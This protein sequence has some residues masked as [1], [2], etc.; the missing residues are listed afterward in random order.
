MRRS[1]LFAVF[2]LTTTSVVAD[3]CRYGF[4][5]GD[6]FSYGPIT[7]AVFADFNE[8]GR[9]DFITNEAA[10]NVLYLN[11]GDGH[12]ER[13]QL[14]LQPGGLAHYDL[15]AAADANGDGHMDLVLDG[16]IAV[17]L[18][19]GKGN[20]GPLIGSG[21]P[22]PRSARL[23]DLN[24][25]GLKDVVYQTSFS[26]SALIV[27]F[28]LGDG[29]FGPPTEIA[30]PLRSDSTY[31]IGDFDGDGAPDLF[32][33]NQVWWNDGKGHFTPS[34][35][36]T[37]D[38]SDVSI[39]DP[40]D[41]DHDGADD[42]LFANATGLLKL[43]RLRGRIVNVT[44]VTSDDP[45][46]YGGNL[47]A[48]VDLDGDGYLDAVFSDEMVVWGS[49]DPTRL[50]T[51]HFDLRTS[52][53]GVRRKG[54]AVFDFDGDGLPDLVALGG[55][56]G[57]A[58]LHAKPGS[59]QLFTGD[60]IGAT[61]AVGDING[62]GSPDR[63]VMD[64]PH[65]IGS[66]YLN[67]GKGHFTFHNSFDGGPTGLDGN[68]AIA[69]F[70]GD[71]NGDLLVMTK[72]L[73][74]LFGD[75]HGSFVSSPVIAEWDS[76]PSFSVLPARRGGRAIALIAAIENSDSVLTLS[77][78]P[79][80]TA[81]LTPVAGITSNLGRLNTNIDGVPAMFVSLDP[82]H[83]EL[84]EYAG[85]RWITIAILNAWGLPIVLDIDGDGIS[86]VVYEAVQGG[87]FMTHVTPSGFSTPRAITNFP[88][89]AGSIHVA[90]VD[91]DGK[92]DLVFFR[93]VYEYSWDVQVAHNTGNGFE[94]TAA[95]T[96]TGG[97]LMTADVNGDGRDD[98]I[99]ISPNRM[100]VLT[101]TCIDV[102]P[103]VYHVIPA[104]PLAGDDV[105]VTIEHGDTN[106]VFTDGSRTP[107]PG[108]PPADGL[109]SYHMG[110]LSTGTH[111]YSYDE[112][113]PH[114]GTRH[115]T[116]AVTVFNA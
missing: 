11:Q 29:H 82:T 30:A 21:T 93:Q 44:P 86:D 2:L 100:E 76:T 59:R 43:I 58:I 12:Y 85:D 84:R 115:A 4:T 110:R 27:Q 23:V 42:L 95:A 22:S 37:A 73:H 101:S 9:I 98:L 41:I 35:L 68:F 87:M 49:P 3:G 66:V 103:V 79:D 72:Q 40:F 113:G 51:T 92:S 1:I 46:P 88:S 26:P 90:D 107:P 7:S 108:I 47:N 56:D 114:F 97:S 20:F 69:D 109:V 71:G 25:D 33:V 39:L 55:V 65:G 36:K 112:S 67:D 62:D 54:A 96:T 94:F 19:D 64:V 61:N 63:I 45:L 60:V 74:I 77:V 17:A 89:A 91:G 83:C 53:P 116:I 70:D 34:K 24:G 18:G 50:E 80:R 102:P 13:K 105:T 99:L 32:W 6:K 52:P 111:T 14:A 81:T 10:G 38:S 5:T 31:R 48:L 16:T 78:A 104:L 15:L 75:G 57:L 106:A 8:D 28:A